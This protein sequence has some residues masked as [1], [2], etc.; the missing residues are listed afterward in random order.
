MPAGW[1]ELADVA[2]PALLDAAAPALL[3]TT[4]GAVGSDLLGAGIT[5]MSALGG[6]YAASAVPGAISS[7]AP[8]VAA[9]TV[10]GATPA[11]IAEAPTAAGPTATTFAPSAAPTPA[12]V[13]SP[14]MAPVNTPMEGVTPAG[15]Q[16]PSYQMNPI[17]GQPMTPDQIAGSGSTATGGNG[18]VGGGNPPPSGLQSGFDKATNWLSDNKG[19]AMGLGLMALSKLG[20]SRPTTFNTPNQ[21]APMNTGYYKL[22]PA[23]FQPGRMQQTTNPV[24][25]TYA[26]YQQNPYQPTG[27]AGGGITSLSGGGSA[28]KEAMD[29]QAQLQQYEAMLTGQN[30]T[31]YAQAAT[32]SWVTSGGINTDTDPNTKDLSPYEAARYR[33]AQSYAKAG[34]PKTAGIGIA[35]ASQNY[36]SINTDPAMVQAAMTAQQQQAQ[37]AAQGGIMGYAG[38][39]QTEYS[40]GGYA[41][42]GNPRLLKGPGD[43]MSD[44][45]PA[46]IAGRQPARLADGEF[47]VPADVVSH[48]GNGSTDAGAKKLH[49]MMDKVRMSRT[50]KKKQAPQVK[51]DKF[52][53]G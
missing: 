10:T 18:I 16:V 20:G 37:G 9:E 19:I 11:A 52:I 45:I 28:Y 44:N 25:P 35:P 43:G 5:D 33:L 15:T 13:P 46:T 29:Q 27:Y 22:N 39:G 2:A 4:L 14:E 17:N 12:P 53:P 47:V 31:P 41:D 32:P 8:S 3:D 48:L 42:G 21:S 34:A 51:T 23:T 50:G 6:E 49:G 36:G 24:M 7:A 40:L 30:Q 1:V 26:N 38:G